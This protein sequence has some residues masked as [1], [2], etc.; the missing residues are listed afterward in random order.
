MTIYHITPKQFAQI[1]RVWCFRIREAS[2]LAGFSA[3]LAAISVGL[4]CH[5]AVH[6]SIR[7]GLG[8]QFCVFLFS[9]L[10]VVFRKHA[11]RFRSQRRE[12]L[13]RNSQWNLGRSSANA[14]TP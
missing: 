7:L 1:D 10:V 11:Q 8:M 13:E 12:F 9:Y 3:L 5:M 2:W 4:G 14:Q 6:G